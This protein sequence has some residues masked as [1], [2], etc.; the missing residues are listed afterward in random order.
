MEELGKHR[1]TEGK[2]LATQQAEAQGWGGGHG[3]DVQPALPV[4]PVTISQV[5]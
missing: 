2:V 4:S 3:F 5:S 1:D